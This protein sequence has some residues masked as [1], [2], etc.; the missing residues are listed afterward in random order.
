MEGRALQCAEP[1]HSCVPLS[2]HS[3]WLAA[4]GFFGTSVGAAVVMLLPAI[5]FSL[6]AVMMAVTVV[7]VSPKT[8]FSLSILCT[9]VSQNTPRLQLQAGRES[10][11]LGIHRVLCLGV[12][13]S[14]PRG[15]QAVS[16][17]PT[18]SAQEPSLWGGQGGPRG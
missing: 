3:G 7:K 11:S 4:I 18:V 5:M 8:F 2:L 12:C 17:T 15:G 6:S 10:R 14:D 13:T 1:L 9:P 16:L